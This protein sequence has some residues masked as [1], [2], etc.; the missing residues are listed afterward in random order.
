VSVTG[1]W[2]LDPPA[3]F[4]PPPRV[5]DFLVSGPPPVYVGF[6]SMTV[7]RPEVMTRSLLDGL[8]RARR[9]AILST[10][11]GGLA[12]AQAGDD[13]LFVGDVPHAWLFP[14]VA[15]IVHHGGAGTTAESLRAGVPQLIV[16]FLSDQPFWGHHVARAG[17]GPEPVPVGAFSAA[18]LADALIRMDRPAMRARAQEI[19]RR[20]R[21]ERGAAGAVEAMER[22]LRR[23]A[24][25]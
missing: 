14:R 21:E 24:V 23:A 13:V 2:F 8:R 9:R 16:P 5:V 6:G 20:V 4:E 11:W 22:H 12:E 3:S 7:E 18:A 25:A 1:A 15:A 17:L 10:G 19:G